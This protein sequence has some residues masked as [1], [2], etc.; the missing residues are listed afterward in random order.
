MKTL[1]LERHPPAGAT[2]SRWSDTLLLGAQ[3]S[4]PAREQEPP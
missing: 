1:L 3:A 2:P 4:P